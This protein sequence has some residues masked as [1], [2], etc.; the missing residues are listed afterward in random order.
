MTALLAWWRGLSQPDR[1]RAYTKLTFQT[2]IAVPVVVGA[3]D[4]PWWGS[5]GAVTAGLAALAAVEVHPDFRTWRRTPWPSWIFAVAAV[6]L[7][8]VMAAGV[9]G[10]RVMASEDDVDGAR[11]VVAI[12]FFLAALCVVPFLRHRWPVLAA[13]AVVVGL[14]MTSTRH[15]LLVV[16]V[17]LAV[18]VFAVG[19]T[20]L[21]WWGLRVIDDLDHARAV[22]GRL[23]VAEERL[24]FSRDLHDVVGRGFSAVAVKSELAATLARAGHAERAATEMEEVKALAVESMEQMRELV[25]GY[26]DISLASEV[27]GAQ[28]LLSAAGC[29]LVVEGDVDRVPAAF[30]DVAA[31]TVRE[32][33]T[34]IVKHSSAAHA[35]LTLGAS[36][37]SLRN[38]RPHPARDQDRPRSGH[39]GLTERLDAVAATLSTSSTDDTYL[40]EVRWPRP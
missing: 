2:A 31:W 36:G 1:Y 33:T 25:R 30:H 27:A 39:R 38:D 15:P 3:T 22:A 14:A 23:Q 10:T 7:V 17:L 6:V 34:N 8:A 20:L 4:V 11:S 5:V 29:T 26:R 28:A 16:P 9:V 40:L 18:G 21:S 32:G 19:I 37:M 35:R 13:G 12:S 24:R